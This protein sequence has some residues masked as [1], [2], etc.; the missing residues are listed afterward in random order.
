MEY[1][2]ITSNQWEELQ[3]AVQERLDNGW[4]LQGGV[5]ASLSENDEYCYP[6]FAQA[7][8]RDKP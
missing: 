1:K 2:I 3:K 6:L 8:V 4:N 5:A 7:V